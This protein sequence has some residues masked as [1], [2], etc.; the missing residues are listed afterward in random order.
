MEMV[1]SNALLPRSGKRVYEGGRRTRGYL[2]HDVSDNPLITIITVVFNGKDHIERTMQS[3]LR[4]TYNNVQFIIIDGGSTDGT[5]DLIR[6]YEAAIDYWIS[7]PDSGLYDAMNK[8]ITASNGSWLN[9][10]NAGDVFHDDDVLQR[11]AR[12]TADAAAG[13]DLIYGDTLETDQRGATFYRTSRQ[14][15][16]VTVGMFACHQSMFFSARS[17]R[18][19]LYDTSYRVAADYH[20]VARLVAN[21]MAIKRVPYPIATINVPGISSMMM[22]EYQND[23]WRVKKQILQV[24]V[25]LRCAAFA[26]HLAAK[27]IKEYFLTAYRGYLSL[28]KG[29]A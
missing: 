23:C 12:E 8:G 9:F 3:V 21:K 28:R 27:F 18:L 29:R 26:K 1:Q 2:K 6:K 11:I 16:Y 22:V 14:P 20:L 5:V 15:Q 7:E 17:M 4:Q 19:F 10:L 13:Y 25:F 24:P